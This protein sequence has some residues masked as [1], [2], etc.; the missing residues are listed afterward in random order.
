MIFS[1]FLFTGRTSGDT[2]LVSERHNPLPARTRHRPPGV[3][4]GVQGKWLMVPDAIRLT[5]SAGDRGFESR[6]PHASSNP[7]GRLVAVNEELFRKIRDQITLQPETHDQSRWEGYDHDPCGTAICVAGWA[8]HFTALAEG[9]S[10][11][12]GTW[13]FRHQYAQRHG[14]R[15]TS[16]S[17]VAR[18]LL[19]LTVDGAEKL[20]YADDEEARALVREYA[21]ECTA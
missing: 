21:R 7:R 13:N 19:G 20:F 5:P 9:V 3:G 17:N 6:L 8:I 10:V 12:D 11:A 2:Q 18:H 15:S 1:S 14:L 4:R 16:Y